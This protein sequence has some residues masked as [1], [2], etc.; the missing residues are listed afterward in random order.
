MVQQFAV[1][2][3]LRTLMSSNQVLLLHITCSVS[4]VWSL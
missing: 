2:S 4:V 3:R 1:A